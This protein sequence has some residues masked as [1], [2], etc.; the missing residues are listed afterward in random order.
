M[1][2]SAWLGRAAPIEFDISS[3][4]TVRSPQP[5]ILMIVMDTTRADHLS[6]YGY[7][8]DTTPNLKKLAQ[9]AALY[10]NAISAADITLSSHASLFTGFYPS[11]HGARGRPPEAV[12]GAPVGQGIPAL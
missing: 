2:G 1:L 7:E 9:D 6:V 4:S 3:S 10:T 8:R 11:W 12:Y 5:N